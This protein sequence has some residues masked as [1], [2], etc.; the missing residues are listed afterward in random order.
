M[1]GS[2]VIEGVFRPMQ[3]WLL[4][5]PQKQ[6]DTR[7][8]IH[9]PDSAQE[10]GP[11]PVRAAGPDCGLKVG[12]VVWIQRFV[13]GE[14]KFVLNGESVYA[15]REKHVNVVDKDGGLVAAG[16]RILVKRLETPERKI[17]KL[18][19]PQTAAETTQECE[20]VSV[21]PKG[22]KGLK[23]GERVMISRYTG[24]EVRHP[25]GKFTVLNENDVIGVL[26]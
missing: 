25:S 8:G 19:I 10:F 18:Y 21:G 14:F 17:G 16:D 24:A 12:D 6:A 5:A 23:G 26:A 13:E 3:D 22:S 4:L 1:L 7:D 15:I 11:C 2:N 20:V 9:I